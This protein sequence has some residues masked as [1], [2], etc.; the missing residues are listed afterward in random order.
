MRKVFYDMRKKLYNISEAAILVGCSVETIRRW[1]RSE[2]VEPF[3]GKAGGEVIQRK[4]ENCRA[5]Y[6]FDNA[7]V[8][9]LKAIQERMKDAR[10][11]GHDRFTR[12]PQR[13]FKRVS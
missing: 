4:R 12:N 10:S 1:I 5:G 11:E 8:R 6:V 2:L 7:L 3:W 13:Q 9:D